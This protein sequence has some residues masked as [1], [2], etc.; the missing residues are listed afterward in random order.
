MTDDPKAIARKAAFA[1]R[2]QA[3][4]QGQGQAAELL[5]DCLAP[6]QGRVLAG[7]MA[8]RTEIDPLPAMIA[9]TGPVCVPVIAGPGRPLRFRQWTH[10]CPMIMGEFGAAI[11][12]EGPWLEPEVLIVPLVAFDRRGYRLGYGG[13]FY[14]RT[15]EGLRAKR[16]TLA[17]GL[18]FA[19]QELPQVPVEPTDQPLDAIVTEAGVLTF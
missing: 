7:Y 2:K 13:G 18:A 17:I 12:A 6:H 16:P 8:M 3:F 4:A 5:A 11:P 9:H 19:A 1:A 14:D 15:L 10:G